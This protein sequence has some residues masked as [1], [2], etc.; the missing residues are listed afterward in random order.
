MSIDIWARNEVALA[1]KKE[2]PDWD[3]ES[4]DYGCSCYQSA[5]KAYES[6]CNDGHS[7][8]SFGFTKNILIRLMNALPLT[9]IEDV[10]ENWN[11]I[12]FLSSEG[13]TEYQCLRMSALFKRVYKD[14]RVE[15]R[16]LDRAVCVDN[17]TGS[18]YHGFGCSIVDKLYPITMPY[19]PKTADKYKVYTEEFLAKGYEGDDGDFNTLAILYIVTPDKEKISID[20]FYGEKEGKWEEIT[21]AEYQERKMKEV[22]NVV[23]KRS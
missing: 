8:M 19:Y 1:C 13:Y 17:N 3:G 6:L 2:N 4:F 7:G 12:T 16:D 10:S 14:G 11:Q 22:E 20:K 9:P 18:T 15:F 21:P 5:L 23:A